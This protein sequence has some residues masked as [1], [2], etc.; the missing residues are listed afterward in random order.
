MLEFSYWPQVFYGFYIGEG[1][2]DRI[3]IEK[4][5]DGDAL[6]LVLLNSNLRKQ[7]SRGDT[8]N[9]IHEE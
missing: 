7:Q 4:D 3:L 1:R 8:K 5:R 2:S 9:N 6:V